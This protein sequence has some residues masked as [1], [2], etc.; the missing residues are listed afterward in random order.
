MAGGWEPDLETHIECVI[1]R[2]NKTREGRRREVK[3]EQK[4]RRE[5]QQE[6]G[7][8]AEVGGAFL[9]KSQDA[10]THHAQVG[11]RWGQV[12][13]NCS[14]QSLAF[15]VRPFKRN[16]SLA[17]TCQ[18]LSFELLSSCPKTG[19]GACLA[20]LSKNEVRYHLYE[21][22]CGTWHGV[23]APQRIIITIIA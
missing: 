6:G 19:G 18:L 3:R 11:E 12:H 2:D 17:T 7:K 15:R 5:E 23:C 14:S 16:P 1:E 20:G 9:L 8:R 22:Y 4:R 13:L 21:A 10:Y